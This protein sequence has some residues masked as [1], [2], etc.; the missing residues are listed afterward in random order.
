MN[1]KQSQTWLNARGAELVVDGQFGPKS[2]AAMI[3]AFRNRSAPAVTPADIA[4]LAARLKCTTRQ[5]GAVAQVEGGGSGWDRSGLLACLYERH[6]LWR[7]V[8]TWALWSGARQAYLSNPTPGGYTTDVND[9]GMNDSWEKLADATAL[10]GVEAALECASFGKFQIMGAHWKALG[11]SSAL[12]FVWQLSRNEAAH[13]DAFG[14]Y[15]EVNRLL[16]ALRA[17]NGDPEN[18]RPLARGYN[19]TGYEKGGYHIKIAAAWRSLA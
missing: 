3:E 11:Y 15:L 9:N 1:T 12:D 7:R 4:A 16:P 2:K 6:Y 14:R 5:I 10:F 17:I 19:G 8:K 13:Y 18:A